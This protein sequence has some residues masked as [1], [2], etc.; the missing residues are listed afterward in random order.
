MQLSTFKFLVLGT[1]NRL[2]EVHLL[3]GKSFSKTLHDVRGHEE[4]PAEALPLGMGHPCIEGSC[5][6]SLLQPDNAGPAFLK[7]GVPS[8]GPG[9][10]GLKRSMQRMM[11]Q[12]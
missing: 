4:A 10:P 8:L 3:M 6:R 2:M 5:Q 1:S 11:P 9:L 12:T 7:P